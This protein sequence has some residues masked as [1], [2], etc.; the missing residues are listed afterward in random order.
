[1]SDSAKKRKIPVGLTLIY[2]L[3]VIG[4]G[5]G[6]S[7]ALLREASI[8]NDLSQLTYIGLVILLN[9]GTAW[10]GFCIWKGDS[11]SY[12]WARLIFLLQVPV[13]SFSKLTYEFYTGAFLGLTFSQEAASKLN[14]NL[15]LG[16]LTSLQIS[17][18]IHGLI[19]GVNLVALAALL[20]LR[21]LG[22]QEGRS[23]AVAERAYEEPMHGS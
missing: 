19:V 8:Q 7:M 3:L 6:V 15:E 1:M 18:G 22:A 10:V 20:Y 5:I 12:R 14:L 17:P 16:S 11:R 9:A 21:A 13:L 23:G 2:L 4:G